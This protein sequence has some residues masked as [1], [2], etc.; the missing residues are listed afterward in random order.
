M[1]SPLN[2][3]VLVE[4]VP[5]SEYQDGV[6]IPADMRD[7]H[8]VARVIEVSPDLA[9]KI[10]LR[11]KLVRYLKGSLTKLSKDE[12]ERFAFIRYRALD[13]IMAG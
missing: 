6:F 12:D 2:D 9:L 1:E 5:E 3:N 8:G 7:E 13:A 10:E 4:I 11:G